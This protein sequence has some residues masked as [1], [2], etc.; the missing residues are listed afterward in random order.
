MHRTP[1]AYPLLRKLLRTYTVFDT[2]LIVT[3]DSPDSVN[4]VNWSK[5]KTKMQPACLTGNGP[6]AINNHTD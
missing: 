3:V 2:Y 5:W 4:V 1:N 6:I